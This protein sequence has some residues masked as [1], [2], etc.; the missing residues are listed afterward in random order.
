MINQSK[1]SSEVMKKIASAIESINT[2]ENIVPNSLKQTFNFKGRKSVDIS[3]ELLSELLPKGSKVCDPFFGSGSFLLSGIKSGMYVEGSELDNYTFSAVRVLL[4]KI[5]S[6]AISQVLNE[7]RTAIQKQIME[8]YETKCCDTINFIDKL[9]FDPENA[10]YYNPQ[11]HRDIK[12]GRNIIMVEKC[13]I[14]GLKTKKFDD[15]DKSVVDKSQLIDTSLFP[16]HNLIVNSRINITSSAG[17]NQYDRNFTNRAK[18][19]LLMIQAEISKIKDNDI[20]EF[21]QHCLVASLPLARIC[22]Y[23]SGSEY[24]Y[25]VMRVQAQEKN[26]WLIF[27]S[28]VA[29]FLR[30]KDE[31]KFAQTDFDKAKMIKLHNK[32]YHVTFNQPQYQN[33]F[34]AVLTDPP[35]TD[36]V[37]FLERSQLFRDW[38]MKFYSSDYKLT[39][40]MLKNEV[41]V[42]NAPSRKNKANESQYYSDLDKM[43]KTFNYITKPSGYVIMVVKLGKKKY[44]QTLGKYINYARKNGF[45]FA[46]SLGIDKN[47]P[48][49][50]KQAAFK[51]TIAKEIMLVFC[52]IEETY[53]Y[54]FIDDDN[55]EKEVVKFVYDKLKS[56]ASGIQISSLVFELTK[57]I[58]S[59]YAKNVSS[60]DQGKISGII[61]SNF[62][63]SDNSVVTID[64]EKLYLELEETSDLFTKLLDIIPVIIKKFDP[65][66]GFTLDDLYYEIYIN[67]LL[68]N[69]NV[70]SKLISQERYEAQIKSLINN[71]CDSN[72]QKYFLKK[73]KSVANSNAIDVSTM[74]GY[75]FEE[76]IKRLLLKLGYHDVNRIGGACDRGVDL[77]AKKQTPSGAKGFIFQCK[78][79]IGNVGST[80]IQRLHSMK[81]QMNPSFNE[82]VCI[83]TSNYTTHAVSEAANTGVQ[84]INGYELMKL[85]NEVFPGEYYHGALD[86][87]ITL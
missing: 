18:A 61:K 71:Y 85:I 57:K 82:A 80:P 81:V 76:L 27:E 38:L 5:D 3:S 30:F 64:P 4:K 40:V 37:P 29:S 14:C 24:I 15:Y 86:L 75:E 12:D 39:D 49:L 66:K 72:E 77:T 78:R 22:Q 41:V 19:A 60:E 8:L 83:T 52:K 32:D 87:A 36:Q 73:Y 53:R 55:Y 47:D 84:L 9:H 46:S 70:F 54:L 74:D 31:F 69:D 2:S 42:T 51:N 13:P 17:A 59:K 28:K 11:V 63:V 79:W 6:G 56:K 58:A 16:N 44:L 23:G 62:S 45:E 50:R 65:I 7:I 67:L 26:V 48:S 21:F 34:D 1:I 43:F 33:Y 35:Y 20:R 68:G 25:Q 10:E